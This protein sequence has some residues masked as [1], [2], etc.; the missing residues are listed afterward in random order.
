[1]IYWYF[2]CCEHNQAH[3]IICVI[4]LR[5]TLV[6][7]FM[8]IITLTSVKIY[9]KYVCKFLTNVFEKVPK[10]FFSSPLFR[11][12]SDLLHTDN[13]FWTF[14]LQFTFQLLSDISYWFILMEVGGGC[15]KT[16]SWQTFVI[17]LLQFSLQSVMAKC[18]NHP[19]CS[20]SFNIN[21]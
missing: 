13:V 9:D 20:F 14:T 16:G 18:F 17:I 3:N 10:T 15:Y 12:V 5:L 6:G 21:L 2:Y 1:M 19:K 4:K 8:T 7:R 11:W